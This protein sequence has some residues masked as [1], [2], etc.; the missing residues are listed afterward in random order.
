MA[1]LPSSRVTRS[2]PHQPSGLA[3]QPPSTHVTCET[4]PPAHHDPIQRIPQASS[5]GERPPLGEWL[6]SPDGT[7]D[8]GDEH[9]KCTRQPRLTANRPLGSQVE[10]LAHAT[11]P[12]GQPNS[13]SSPVEFPAVLQESRG[14][15]PPG[16]SCARTPPVRPSGR[17][18]RSAPTSPAPC[19]PRSLKKSHQRRDR[20]PPRVPQA[21]QNDGGLPGPGP[22]AAH[23]SGASCGAPAEDP[24]GGASS[25]RA[26]PRADMPPNPQVPK[27]PGP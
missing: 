7:P 24:P 19:P 2:P 15:E 18:H 13:Q 17:S 1:R 27:A 6:A 12:A 4:A 3:G 22:G 9:R 8:S 16:G 23:T 11:R 20:P 14:D 26:P 21:A 10:R 25:R 5:E